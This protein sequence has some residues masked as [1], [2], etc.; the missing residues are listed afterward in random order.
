VSK[1]VRVA[2]SPHLNVTGFFAPHPTQYRPRFRT[3][4]SILKV[5][6]PGFYFWPSCQP[7]QP[8][9]FS[10]FNLLSSFSLPFQVF[11]KSPGHHHPHLHRSSLSSSTG[12]SSTASST[13]SSSS[14]S[15]LSLTMADMQS[16]AAAAAAGNYIIQVRS[17]HKVGSSVSTGK[18]F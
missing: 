14:L 15:L 11:S 13:S 3:Q 5:S 8:V 4:R 17:K 10:A 16:A 9:A 18:P 1:S 12:S 2:R 6:F 7:V